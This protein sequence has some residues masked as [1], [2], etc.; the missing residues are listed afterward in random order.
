MNK[1]PLPLEWINKIFMRLHG[2]FGNTFFDKYRIGQ[3]NQQGQDIG[4]ENAKIVWSEELAG[5]TPERIKAALES[6]YEY[7]PS[8]DDFKANC[9]IRKQVEDYKALSAPVDI[10]ANRKNAEKVHNFVAENFKSRTDFRAWIKPIL[11]N[12]K[13]YPDISLKLAKEVEAMTA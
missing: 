7:P 13:A 3:L 10:E 8:C 9:Y 1:Q 5:T 2:R 12:P 11:A 6:N 4:V